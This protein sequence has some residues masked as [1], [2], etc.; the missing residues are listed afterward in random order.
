MPRKDDLSFLYD[1]LKKD[2]YRIMDNQGKRKVREV[3]EEEVIKMYDEYTPK[4]KSKRR[5]Q[6]G[7]FLD[8]R[9]W[10]DEVTLA[11]NG[12]VEY[13]LV[14]ETEKRGKATQEKRLD[15]IIETGKGYFKGIKV[16]ARPVYGRTIKRLTETDSLEKIIC[17][18]L[19]RNGWK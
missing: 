16:P 2:T 12:D 6:K 8:D 17:R 19:K 4:Q 7:G 3:Y 18:E 9:N 14:N 5:L 10:D 13:F 15:E 11:K 1:E